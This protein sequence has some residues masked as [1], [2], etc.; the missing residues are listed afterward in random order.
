MV[1]LDDIEK[2]ITNIINNTS[3]FDI[4][5]GPTIAEMRETLSGL[6]HEE[7]FKQ[8]TE[9]GL[10]NPL[11]EKDFQIIPK[12][13]KSN[14]DWIEIVQ[15]NLDKGKY[16]FDEKYKQ[17]LI[18][19]VKQK[20]EENNALDEELFKYGRR[21]IEGYETELP[22]DLNE[23]QGRGGQRDKQIGL[24]ERDDYGDLDYSY[25]IKTEMGHIEEKTIDNQQ[26]SVHLDDS[27]WE[28]REDDTI[29]LNDPRV[30]SMNNYFS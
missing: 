26:N 24:W 6:S 21:L 7:Q 18:D 30:E 16:D 14:E 12:K 10:L 19:E 25:E 2:I 15:E 29:Q 17:S 28:Y 20:K 13:K 1:N 8:L 4:K 3:P 11:E 22:L 27:A 9:Q 5:C 23:Y